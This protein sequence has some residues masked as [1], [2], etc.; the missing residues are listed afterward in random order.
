MDANKLWTCRVGFRCST[1]SVQLLCIFVVFVVDRSWFFFSCCSIFTWC[2]WSLNDI[3]IILVCL[4]WKHYQNN[5]RSFSSRFHL[6]IYS[7]WLLL[8]AFFSSRLMFI[9]C[10]LISMHLH[11]Q[12]LLCVSFFS[13]WVIRIVVTIHSFSFVNKWYCTA[14]Y[15]LVFLWRGK[16]SEVMCIDESMPSHVCLRVGNPSFTWCFFSCSRWNKAATLS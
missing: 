14:L 1:L 15:A 7:M 6:F 9:L 5:E 13:R 3:R 4:R 10:V 2:V 12:G 8:Y 11:L 16:K